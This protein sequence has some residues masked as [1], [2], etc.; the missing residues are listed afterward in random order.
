MYWE[1]SE[2]DLARTLSTF[3]NKR[4]HTY[5]RKPD[6][7]E[8]ARL[9]SVKDFIAELAHG[10]IQLEGFTTT[11]REERSAPFR[12]RGI[13][14]IYTI[15]CGALPASE[16]FVCIDCGPSS[17]TKFYAETGERFDSSVQFYARVYDA[18]TYRGQSIYDDDFG[19][20]FR[21][22]EH[23]EEIA[24]E[25][26]GVRAQFEKQQ[27]IKELTHDSIR[28]WFTQICEELG[29]SYSIDIKKIHTRLYVK[30]DDKTQLE[31]VVQHSKF[32]KIMPELSSLIQAYTAVF[33]ANK[34]RAL[35]T[36]IDS[37]LY[38]QDPGK[39]QSEDEY[40]Q[41]KV[42]NWSSLWG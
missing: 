40:Y 18:L 39:K 36:D 16:C 4:I 27:K 29:C 31:I 14:T 13:H 34:V 2:T 8:A 24:A 30:L 35:I 12:P 3:L 11:R 5:M 26:P 15:T 23:I 25:L 37:W 9:H 10:G 42:I 33:K 7:P 1:Y 22:L 20:V 17:S 21:F 6:G 28:T 19:F 38:W 41:E 32:Q